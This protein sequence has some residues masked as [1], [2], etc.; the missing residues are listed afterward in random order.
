MVFLVFVV[1]GELVCWGE[2]C[3]VGVGCIV[4]I[5]VVVGLDWFCGGLGVIGEV[6]VGVFLE[7]MVGKCNCCMWMY[8]V[9]GWCK[10]GWWLVDWGEFVVWLVC[11]WIEGD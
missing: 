4:S 7:I 5:V 10:L 11:I 2:I 8:M 9:I 6:L 3:L 1:V